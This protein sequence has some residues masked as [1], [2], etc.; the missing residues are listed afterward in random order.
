MQIYLLLLLVERLCCYNKKDSA[1]LSKYRYGVH[2]FFSTRLCFLDVDA[3]L[4]LNHMM[5]FFFLVYQLMFHVGQLLIFKA[6]VISNASLS[7]ICLFS[8]TMILFPSLFCCSSRSVI[9]GHSATPTLRW[10]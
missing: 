2:L 4:D 5:I 6:I 1:S 9:V 8:L 10:R 3:K 7:L